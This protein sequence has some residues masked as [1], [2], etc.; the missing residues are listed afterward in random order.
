[1]SQDPFGLQTSLCIP[2]TLSPQ[3]EVYLEGL[4]EIPATPGVSLRVTQKKLVVLKLLY[5]GPA[6]VSCD[7]RTRLACYDFLVFLVSF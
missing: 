7:V 5:L 1:M 6:P 4:A 3:G 2:M